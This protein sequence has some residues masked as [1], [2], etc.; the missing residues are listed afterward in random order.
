MAAT[1]P[2][3]Q[4][5]QGDRRLDEFLTGTDAGFVTGAVI[6]I[7]GGQTLNRALSGF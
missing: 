4:I 6:P 2:L 1:V 3:G 5:R 7:D